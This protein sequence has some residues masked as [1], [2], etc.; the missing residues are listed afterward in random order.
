MSQT[1]KV[2][3]P[4]GLEFLQICGTGNRLGARVAGL[5]RKAA[6]VI[7][8]LLVPA[9]SWASGEVN[10][11]HGFEGTAKVFPRSLDSYADAGITGVFEKLVHRIIEEPFNLVATLFFLAAIIHTFMAS[12]LSAISHRWEEEHDKKKRAGQVPPNSI[13]MGARLLH[14]L[15]E[16]E[17]VFGIWA[18]VL[19]AAVALHFDRDTAISYLVNDVNFTEAMF[20]V[21]IM[22]LASTRPI[23][24]LAENIISR[25]AGILGGSL[26]VWWMTILILGPLLGSFITE[27]AAMTITALLLASKFYILCPSNRFKYATLGLLFVSV[28]IGG[29][30]THFAAPPVLMVAG[31]WN[32]D[33]SFM[34][35]HF[36][37]KS[38]LAILLSTT[39]Y[40][41]FFRKELKELSQAFQFYELK[42]SVK[43]RFLDRVHFESEVD[44]VLQEND[45]VEG[46]TDGVRKRLKDISHRTSAKM[47]TRFLDAVAEDGIQPAL[48]EQAFDEVYSDVVKSRLQRKIQGALPAKERAPWIDPDWD[49]R[50]DPVPA[51]VIIVHLMFIVWTVVNAHHP[52][53]FIP[54][55]LFFLAFANITEQYQNRVNIRASLLVGFFLGGLVI[56]GGLQGWWIEPVLGSLS[57]VPLM[58]AATG[59]T[60]FNDN[61]AITYLSTLVPNFSEGAKYAVVAGAVAGGG[62]TV[63]ANAPN[64]A[65]QSILKHHFEHG[66]SALY[67]LAGA[68]VPTLVAL[69]I[70]LIAG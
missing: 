10:S 44:R 25:I 34:F 13:P 59:L 24:K 37:L 2:T 57:E 35:T 41:V 30:L 62:L 47:R 26:T 31:P 49:N 16:V 64:P 43:H 17:T 67:L 20:V 1:E 5:W 66:V 4:L 11:I 32:W 33:I 53:M 28:S 40:A 58:L 6:V 36:G 23:L 52:Q 39:A 54:G 19:L 38:I 45:V 60:A 3:V 48:T 56:H 15:G 27:P 50:D 65:G 69:L 46:F 29:T 68:L 14:F 63:I 70:F 8:V 12:R 18:V 51:W 22:T 42:R 9:F 21:V 7:A 55:L 61:S